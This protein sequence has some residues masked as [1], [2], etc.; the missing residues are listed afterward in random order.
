MHKVLVSLVMIASG[1][2]VHAQ[3]PDPDPNPDPDPDPLPSSPVPVIGVWHYTEVTPVSSTC[4]VVT[5]QIEEGSFGIDQ[6]SGTA[7]RVVPN[8]GTAPFTCNLAAAKFDCPNRATGTETYGGATLSYHATANGTFSDASHATG[9]QLATVTCAG[10]GCAAV[11]VTFP[12]SFDVRF[13][14]EAL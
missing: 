2:V 5:Q 10:T 7:F 13:K 14:I 12:C 1:C 11:G 3:D 6:A 8:D 4:G 9:S